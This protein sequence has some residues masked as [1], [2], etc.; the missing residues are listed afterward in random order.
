VTADLE[1]STAT[2]P[3]SLDDTAGSRVV[4]SHLIVATLFLFVT[5]VIGGLAVLQLVV[6]GVFDGVA[7]LG[8]GRLVPMASSALL[9]G[10][11]A[12]GLL[13]GAHY[14]LPRLAMHSL[15]SSGLA[16]LSLA[17][18]AV[19]VVVGMVGIELGHNE[20]RPYLEM[21]LYADAV[22][23]VGI[24]LAA[25]V[26]TR[27]VSPRRHTML[28][29][30]WY[31]LASSWLAVLTFLVG[32]VPGFAGF[33]GA[34]QTAFYRAAMTGFWFAAAG[35]G[36]IYY[37]IPRLVGVGQPRPSSL[38]ALGFWSLAVVWGSTGPIMYIYGPGPGWYQTLGVA[39]SI[40]L[41]VP[42]LLIVADFFVAMRGEWAEVVDRGAL[43]FVLIGSFF[44]LL[45]PVQTLV[46]A[47]RTSSA[48]VQFTE[49]V[50][51]AD[52]LTF[53]GAL[54]MW[55]FAL[56]YWRRGTGVAGSAMA[57][58]HLRLSV[59]G[60]AILLAAMWMAGAATGFT[61]AGGANGGTFTSFGVTW[62]ETQ[63]ALDPYLVVRAVGGGVYVVAQ[64]LFVIA[65]WR[66]SGER[67]PIRDLDPEPF[68][69]EFAGRSRLPTWRSVR[70]GT[71]G[72][73]AAAFLLTVFFPAVDPATR[74]ATIL[75]DRYRV[76]PE[77]S[78]LAQGRQVYLAEGC[79]YCHTQQV[80]PTVTDAGLGAIS[81]A[82]DYVHETPALLG[83]ERLGPDLM[84]VGTR[85]PSAVNLSLVVTEPRAVYP[86]STMPAYD[87]LSDDD[88]AALVEYL[89]SLR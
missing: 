16:M 48:V 47:L 68:D 59:L 39:F 74:T 30:H 22:V 17:A 23:W 52:A 8:Y 14:V 84:H 19:G 36:L 73:F 43:S 55:I 41:F 15:R 11:I 46:Q 25:I 44:F 51:A 64:L 89:M 49:F 13:G 71:V 62:L 29:S 45:I 31:L 40:A 61:W 24:V 63:Q 20:G 1:A 37:L 53:L 88:L 56:A 3:A 2:E 9:Y 58:W 12:L 35:V 57:T 54:S 4:A 33:T 6:P 80:R 85:I 26:V 83:T 86:W 82:G 79:Y 72:L 38:S 69:L 7:Q 65:V 60:L 67:S 50:P 42:V 81:V 87:Q 34:M 76:Y 18:I 78:S 66:G 77:G 21:P 75:A 32:N 70:Y 27:N 28:A 5:L 10:W